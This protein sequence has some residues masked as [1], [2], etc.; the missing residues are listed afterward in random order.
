MVKRVTV[1][2]RPDQTARCGVDGHVPLGQDRK[3]HGSNR[4]QTRSD[5]KNV[6]FSNLAT[7]QALKEGRIIRFY[8]PTAVTT[9]GQIGAR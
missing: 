2:S 8:R 5:P 7:C 3:G 4:S 1:G 9:V 6:I